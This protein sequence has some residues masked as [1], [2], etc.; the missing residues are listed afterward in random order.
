MGKPD[1][2]IPSHSPRILLLTDRYAPSLGGVEKQC[3]LLAKEFMRRGL[4][5]CV[6]TDRYLHSLPSREQQDGIRIYRIRSLT[7]L[8]P[9]F[10]KHAAPYKMKS[11]A[12]GGPAASFRMTRDLHDP[13][14]FV[15][16]FYRLLFYKIPIMS[17]GAALFCAL[18]RYR[19]E[20]D[21]I[22]V[23][24]THW[25]A[26][27]AVLAGIFLSKPVVAR[28]A[29]LN[30]I[31]ALDDF[32]FRHHTKRLLLRH[33]HFI[34]LSSS[35]YKNLLERGVRPEQV[36]AIPNS[37]HRTEQDPHIVQTPLSVLFV[38]NIV[39]DP[40]QKGLDILLKAWQRVSVKIP[41]AH[42]TI[43]GDGDYSEFRTF[44]GELGILQC[45]QFIGVS[46]DVNTLFRTHAIFVLPSRYEGMSNALL[47]A[48][49]FAKACVVTA[50]SGSDDLITH[51]VNGLKVEPG[52]ETALAE[53]I[54]FL[55]E[56]ESDAEVY[57]NAAQE[58]VRVHHSPEII[59]QHYLD[60]Y[61]RLLN[62][63]ANAS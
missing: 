57:G 44:A 37:V 10:Q 23:M 61:T 17:F 7:F 11:L 58:Y 33:C 55:M 5:T 26:Y 15:R 38:G 16:I 4:T 59:S 24:Q 46:Y 52:Q 42:L 6:V 18:V 19:N 36:T 29:S 13:L 35:L 21:V 48:M 50:V 63:T 34:A 56:H 30:A 41:G 20:Y 25:L 22:Q 9:F 27:P 53:A 54:I 40:L 32:P 47:E 60:V 45:V 2:D 51:Q 28:E 3:G 12:P 31:D 14:K 62:S 8:R 43:A 49:S 1:K 39:N